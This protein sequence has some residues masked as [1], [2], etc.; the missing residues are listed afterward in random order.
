MSFEE[1]ETVYARSQRPNI[2]HGCHGI[3]RSSG[4]VQGSLCGEGRHGEAEDEAKEE[5]G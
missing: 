5:S 2:T 4:G 3:A 1:E